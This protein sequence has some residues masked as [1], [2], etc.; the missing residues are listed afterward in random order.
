MD[1]KHL[2]NARSRMRWAADSATNAYSKAGALVVMPDNE[3]IRAILRYLRDAE[4]SLQTAR[5]YF[6]LYMDAVEVE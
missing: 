5:Q 6:D 4:S 3:E 2:E 1:E